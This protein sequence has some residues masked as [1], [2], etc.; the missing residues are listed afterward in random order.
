MVAIGIGCVRCEVCDESEEIIH[1]RA[2]NK[3]IAEQDG[4]IPVNGIN[5]W[6]LLVIKNYQ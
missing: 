4:S 2:Y 3:N 5:A 6:F 1:Y